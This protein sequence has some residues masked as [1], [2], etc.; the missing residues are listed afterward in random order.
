MGTP[1]LPA[2]VGS[3][4]WLSGTARRWF[5]LITTVGTVVTVAVF[6]ATERRLWAW[7]AIAFL[8]SLVVALAWT[9]HD[10]HQVRIRAQSRDGL[11]TRREKL[12]A[13]V[14]AAVIRGEHGGDPEQW[15]WDRYGRWGTSTAELLDAALGPAVAKQLWTAMRPPTTNLNQWQA[16]IR[17][18]VDFLKE[19]QPTLDSLPIMGDWQP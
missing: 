6:L 9:A 19:L 5:A 18:G 15:N 13:L 2:G 11:E 1:R 10:E 12:K 7:L 14:Q 8:A 4:G 3:F 17:R 16:A